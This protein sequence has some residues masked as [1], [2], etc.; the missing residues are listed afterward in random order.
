MK[1]LWAAYAALCFNTMG[2]ND[3][4]QQRDAIFLLWQT[5]IT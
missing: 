2:E 1:Q 3:T 4:I 5:G